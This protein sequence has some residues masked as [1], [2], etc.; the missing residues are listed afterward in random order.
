MPPAR[1]INIVPPF[2]FKSLICIANSFF[3]NFAAKK[4]KMS[5]VKATGT[6]EKLSKNHFKW[7]SKPSVLYLSNLSQ[8]LFLK[9]NTIKS[10]LT[11]L[12]REKT[13]AY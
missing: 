2:L 8:I 7:H 11:L 1:E 9:L 10:F 6:W 5:L 12:Q 3:I 13:T 4:K